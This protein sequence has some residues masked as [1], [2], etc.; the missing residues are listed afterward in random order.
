MTVKSLGGK[1]GPQLWLF[2]ASR[3]LL[4]SPSGSPLFARSFSHNFPFADKMLTSED[5]DGMQ[6]TARRNVKTTSKA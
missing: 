5:V 2:V 4:T 6:A 3:D 1:N